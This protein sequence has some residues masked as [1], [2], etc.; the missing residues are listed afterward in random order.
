M[1]VVIVKPNNGNHWEYSHTWQVTMTGRLIM[2]MLEHTCGITI[3]S[4]EYLQEQIEMD[5][6]DWRTFLHR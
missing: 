5:Q 2:Q 1:H 4:E 3:T 6:G